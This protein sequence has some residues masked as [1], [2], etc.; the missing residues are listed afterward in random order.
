MQKVTFTQWWVAW[1]LSAIVLLCAGFGIVTAAH[2]SSGVRGAVCQD[3]SAR[4]PAGFGR[5]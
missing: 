1:F 3:V 5:A 2:A 4:Y